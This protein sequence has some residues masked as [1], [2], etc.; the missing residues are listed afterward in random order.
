MRFSEALIRAANEVAKGLMLMLLEFNSSMTELFSLSL[1]VT[2]VPRHHRPSRACRVCD[3][4]L[5]G[6][7]SV[8]GRSAA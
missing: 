3:V 4:T 1:P 6:G 2:S 5:P 7:R 8:G